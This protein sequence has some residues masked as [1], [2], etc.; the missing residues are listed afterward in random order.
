M[1]A[2]AASQISSDAD[3]DALVCCL[4]GSDVH[5][6]PHYLLLQ[7]DA[8]DGP[9]DWGVHLEVDDQGHGDYDLIRQCALTPSH[10]AVHLARPLPGYPDVSVIS[11]VLHLDAAAFTALG[12]DL[13]GI[14]RGRFHSLLTA[15]RS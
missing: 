10:L 2:F 9:D 15:E 12:S 14:F 13:A 8:H 4:R 5:G 11:V 7:R 3:D 1:I 6:R